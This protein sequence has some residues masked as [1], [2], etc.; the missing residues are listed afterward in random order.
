MID[1]GVEIIACK[2]CAEE[3]RCRVEDLEGCG[4]NIFLYR[5]NLLRCLD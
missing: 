4:I 5:S 3:D 2:R 1:D